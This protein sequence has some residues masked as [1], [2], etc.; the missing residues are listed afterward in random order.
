M[1]SNYI[2]IKPPYTKY[3]RDTTN[4]T[5]I[6][7]ALSE[8]DG[9]APTLPE[10]PPPQQKPSQMGPSMNSVALQALINS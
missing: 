2:Q 3:T 4:Y 5:P 9:G 7:R 1:K 10:P 6:L 8:L